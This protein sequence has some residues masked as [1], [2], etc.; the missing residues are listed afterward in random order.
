MFH[1]FAFKKSL[2]ALV[3]DD[4]GHHPS[5]LPSYQFCSIWLSVSRG[6]RSMHFR[7]HLAI[8]VSSHINNKHSQLFHWQPFMPRSTH[9]VW[10]LMRRV[11]D[12]ELFV[13]F[14][15]LYFLIQVYFGFMCP[16]NLLPE[17]GRLL[18]MFSHKVWR[19][20]KCQLDTWNQLQTIYIGLEVTSEQVILL[21]EMENGGILHKMSVILER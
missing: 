21:H 1:F 4:S 17:L 6:H 16:K 15:M 12:Q 9:R 11:L 18:S 14:S 5:V 19:A 7:I 8:S 13:F 10:R 3:V 20:A 2:V